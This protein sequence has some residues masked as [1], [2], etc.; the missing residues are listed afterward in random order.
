MLVYNPISRGRGEQRQ[1]EGRRKQEEQAQRGEEGGE[2]S[3]EQERSQVPHI[4]LVASS[5]G[6]VEASRMDSLPTPCQHLSLPLL[7]PLPLLLSLLLLF[8][9][10]QLREEPQAR[11]ASHASPAS[12]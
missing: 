12:T 3:G 6:R 4:L 8:P 1:G 5:S 9:T 2:S 10:A 7:F 11:S